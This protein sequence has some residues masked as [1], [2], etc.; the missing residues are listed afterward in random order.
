VGEIDLKVIFATENSNKFQKPR[1][2]KEKLVKDVVTL[3]PMAQAT[4]V[5][6]KS[7]GNRIFVI[8]RSNPKRLVTFM[9]L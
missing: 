9:I 8:S 3:G 6:M 2:W 1:F 4:L 7:K 5:K